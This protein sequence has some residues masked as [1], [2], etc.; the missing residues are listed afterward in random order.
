MDVN[1]RKADVE[2]SPFGSV[3]GGKENTVWS[4]CKDVGARD[5]QCIDAI[6]GQSR[7]DRSPARAAVGGKEHTAG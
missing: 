1:I 5:G 7:I 6:V 2:V 4:S 3:V